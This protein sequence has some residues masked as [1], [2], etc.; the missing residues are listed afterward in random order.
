MTMEKNNTPL[1]LLIS[2]K[3]TYYVDSFLKGWKEVF[4]EMN[5][6][7]KPKLSFEGSDK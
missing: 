6:D 2:G 7:N 1:N 5:V 4:S 3:Q